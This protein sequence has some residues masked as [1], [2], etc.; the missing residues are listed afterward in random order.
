MSPDGTATAGTLYLHGRRSQFAVRVLGRQAGPRLAVSPGHTNM[1]H[2]VSDR[3]V[4]TRLTTPVI[5][6]ISMT[7]RPGNDVGVI[8]LSVSGARMQSARPLRPGSR[9]HVQLTTDVRRVG[10]GAQVLRCSVA[11][12]DGSGVL[13]ADALK[14]EH[15]CNLLWEEMTRGYDLPAEAQSLPASNDPG[16]AGVDDLLWRL[17]DMHDEGDAYLALKAPP[18][19]HSFCRRRICSCGPVS[20]FTR[21]GEASLAAPMRLESRRPLSDLLR[22]TSHR[23]SLRSSP[24]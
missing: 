3:R 15:R 17:G 12:I 5:D 10:L 23:A 8:D 18:H 19:Y 14:F 16:A 24:E 4:D 2:P 11:S 13:Y 1:A 21:F 7:L 20:A 6:S 22:S 9:V